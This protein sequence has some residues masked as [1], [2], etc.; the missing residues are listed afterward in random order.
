MTRGK[1]L[2][3][4]ETERILELKSKGITPK[5]IATRLGIDR[6]TVY[7]VINRTKEKELLHE[8]IGTN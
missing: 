4:K 5:Q 3:I 2:T 6:R 1:H 7:D 8:H